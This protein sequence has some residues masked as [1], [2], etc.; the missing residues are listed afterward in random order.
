MGRLYD[1]NN[2]L[3]NSYPSFYS[4]YILN[5]LIYK[6]RNLNL[7]ISVIVVSMVSVLYEVFQNFIDNY[8]T[9]DFNDLLFIIFGSLAFFIIHFKRTN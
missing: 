4:T 1:K 8:V 3:T 2:L 6:Y 7:Y 5:Y 9:F